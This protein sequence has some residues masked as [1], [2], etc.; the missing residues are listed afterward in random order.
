METRELKPYIVLIV[1]LAAS[2]IVYALTVNF[3]YSIAMAGVEVTLPHR[4]G[5]WEGKELRYCQ[6]PEHQRGEYYAEDLEDPDTCPDCGQSLA[7]MTYMERILLPNDTTILKKRYQHPSDG[8]VLTSIVLSGVERSSIHRPEVCLRGQNQRITGRRV[9]P[10]PIEGRKD[11]DVMVLD[12]RRT[13]M[14]P[15]G[16]P[17]DI[18]SYYAYWFVG[19][20]RET[21]H[22]AER[23]FWMA[24]DS[25]FHRLAHRWAYIA[26]AG[27]RAGPDDEGYLDEIRQF[28]ADIYPQM[29][30]N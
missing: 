15:A 21:P 1:L 28:I 10:I 18:Y 12:I 7:G 9:V 13:V 20:G 16:R 23:M 6:N 25:I 5:E 8:E 3:D 30:L 4:I 19:K 11:L 17:F 22:H 24:Y 2:S 14:G 26:V 29:A 27:L